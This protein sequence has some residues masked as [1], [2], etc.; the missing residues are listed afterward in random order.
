VLNHQKR[1]FFIRGSIMNKL[2]SLAISA[3]LGLAISFSASA[4]THTFNFGNLLSGN[5]PASL[6]SA[7]LSFDDVLHEFS[8]NFNDPTFGSSAYL[9]LVAVDYN[10]G[11]NIRVRNVSGGVNNVN[12]SQSNVPTNTYDF[13]FKIGSNGNR[14]TNG[15]SVEWT[16]SNFDFT[17]LG[18]SSSPF[19]V[20]VQGITVPRLNRNAFDENEFEHEH[21]GGLSGWYTLSPVPEPE[22]YAMMLAG[23]GVMGAVA[24]RKQKV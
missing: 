5:G 15:E 9:D 16:S 17:K 19:A 2:I 22:T 1:D 24:R 10:L 4:T 20:H 11:R 8:L 7:S 6:N 13:V 23:L 18:T 14:L 21:E 12:F 3:T